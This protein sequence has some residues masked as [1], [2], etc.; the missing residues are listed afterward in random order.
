M[1]IRIR[2]IAIAGYGSLRSIR[3]PVGQLTVFVGAIPRTVIKR[4]GG[5]WIEGLKLFGEFGADDEEDD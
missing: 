3:F 2:E 4:D 5:A 1:A